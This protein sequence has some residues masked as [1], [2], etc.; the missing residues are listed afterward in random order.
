[1]AKE[2]VVNGAKLECKMG[3]ASSNLV[4][5]PQHRVKLG[6]KFKANIGD[7]K[8]MVNVMPFG[9]CKSLA[10][11]AV[12]AATAAAK[13][14]LT[15]MPCTPA[16]SIWISGKPDLLLDGM[17][18]LMRGDKALCPLGA[19]MISVVDSGQV[20]GD[21]KGPAVKRVDGLKL[22]TAEEKGLTVIEYGSRGG[23][24][25]REGPSKAETKRS[26][27]TKA[28][29]DEVKEYAEYPE[30]ISIPES[31]FKKIP[32][33][34]NK[35]MRK[36]YKGKKPVLIKEWERINGIDWPRHTEDVY[37]EET[38]EILA[39]AGWQ[40]EAHH[41]QPLGLGGKNE[42]NNITPLHPSVHHDK[43]VVHRSGGPYDALEKYC[44]GEE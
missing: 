5:L 37:D 18:A 38:G 17:P 43:R 13:G 36:E 29:I 27:L 19:S 44:M 26:A 12:A 41:I 2:Y 22:L 3:S 35:K 25:Q 34:E 16:C 23:K 15:P 6:G 10:N 9:K 11:P 4:V 24:A 21:S 33:D 32:P 30:T 14:K 20:G 7:C 8:P 1:M 40:Y 39:Y 42:A 28:Y 31:P